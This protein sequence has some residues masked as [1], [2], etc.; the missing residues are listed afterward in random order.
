[1]PPD[2]YIHVFAVARQ[3]FVSL[4]MSVYLGEPQEVLHKGAGVGIFDL[5]DGN[6]VLRSHQHVVVS[7]EY[8][9]QVETP[10]KDHRESTRDSSVCPR[11]LTVF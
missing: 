9:C 7:V 10:G 8:G 11:D 4:V 1:M 6:L 5:H 3:S 2:N